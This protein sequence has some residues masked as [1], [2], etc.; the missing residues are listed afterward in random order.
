[1]NYHTVWN[2]LIL[3]AMVIRDTS[4]PGLPGTPIFLSGIRC[5]S[6]IHTNILDCQALDRGITRCSHDEDVVVHCEGKILCCRLTTLT[7]Y[8]VVSVCQ[9]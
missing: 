9:C 3:G 6:N 2:L 5:D 4:L 7:Y 1:M 8:Y